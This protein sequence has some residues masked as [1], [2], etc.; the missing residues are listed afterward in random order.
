MEPQIL[1]MVVI[2]ICSIQS[3]LTVIFQVSGGAGI[4]SEIA[5]VYKQNSSENTGSVKYSSV[6]I[7]VAL[8]P[9]TNCQP[10]LIFFVTY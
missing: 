7:L 8:W 2:Y 3:F 5:H 1:A 4:A 6:G 10:C 9:R